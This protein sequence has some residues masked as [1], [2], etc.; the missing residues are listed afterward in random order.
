MTVKR[1]SRRCGGDRRRRP[2]ER[3]APSITKWRRRFGGPDFRQPRGVAIA[4]HQLVSTVRHYL[5]YPTVISHADN[6]DVR[7]VRIA[8]TG[9]SMTIAVVN[10]KGGSGK[11]TVALHLA[12]AVSQQGRDVAVLDLDPQ[13][14]AVR[15]RQRRS[16]PVPVVLA[17]PPGRLRDELEQV[18]GAGAEVVFLDAPPRAGADVAAREAAR[19][20]DLVVVPVRPTVVDLEAAAETLARIQNVTA[21][22]VIVLNQVPTRGRDADEAAALLAGQGV[23]V[24][25]ARI[26]NRIAY[27]RSLIDGRVAQELEPGGKAADEIASVCDVLIA[28]IRGKR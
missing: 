12:V 14:T 24:C 28:H 25:P 13:Q 5:L 6:G 18:T 27:S 7:V 10:A 26:G 1:Y 22:V 2:A 9:G 11:T 8:H 21:R 16:A 4:H 20:A 15:W 23:E 3:S 19:V 17:A